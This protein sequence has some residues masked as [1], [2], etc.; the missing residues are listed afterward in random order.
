MRYADGAIL[1]NVRIAETDEGLKPFKLLMLGYVLSFK[2]EVC[3]AYGGI[4][5][6]LKF[7]T[8]RIIVHTRRSH[9]EM[10]QP[11]CKL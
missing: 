1:F 6:P 2:N 8:W 11:Q 3:M 10:S 4:D 5:H 7:V 9:Y